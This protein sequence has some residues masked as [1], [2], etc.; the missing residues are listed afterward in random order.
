MSVLMLAA[1]CGAALEVTANGD[2]EQAA[3]EA[4]EALFNAGF[5]ELE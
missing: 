2:D 1:P 5:G 4:L 3:L